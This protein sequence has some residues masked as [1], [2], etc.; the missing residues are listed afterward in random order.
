MGSM[1]V[2]ESEAAFDRKIN[3]LCQELGK[4]GQSIVSWRRK[5]VC[6]SVMHGFGVQ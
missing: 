3:E 5:H 4:K 2:M 6:F 1:A